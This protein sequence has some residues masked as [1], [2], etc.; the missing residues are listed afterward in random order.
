MPGASAADQRDLQIVTNS[1]T[2]SGALRFDWPAVHVG[3]AEYP[4]GPTGVTVFH[5][6]DRAQVAIDYRGGGPG[7]VNAPYV[8]LGY[9]L[10]ELDSLVFAGGSWYG[11]EATTAVASA[12]KDDG[13]RDGD[14]FSA[15]ANIA[16]SIGSIIFDFGP[17]RLNEIYPDKRLAQAAYRASEPGVF[18]LGATGAGRLAKSGGFFGCDAHSGQGGAFRQIGDLKVAAFTVVNSVG[19]ITDRSGNVQACYSD[20]S[21]TFDAPLRATDLM[22]KK[23]AATGASS[24][25]T[26]SVVIINQAMSHAELDRL[27]VQVHMSM[28]RAIQP[29]ATIYD[30][31]VLYAVTTNELKK[32]IMAPPQL[33][34]VASELM[35]DAVLSS[36][37]DQPRLDSLPSRALPQ[38]DI[39]H[40]DGRY[41]FSDDAEL[42]ISTNGTRVFAQSTDIRRVYQFPEQEPV[43][44]EALSDGDYHLPGR[45]PLVLRFIDERTIALNPG[46]WEQIGHRN[47]G[48]NPQ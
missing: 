11:L 27:A 15:E 21:W 16:M 34:V 37:P 5:F 26:I 48:A 20:P 18:P 45:Y 39:A 38:P 31:D 36:V 41:R 13:L 29:F 2:V 10:Q 23:P 17:R 47:K 4:S 42:E 35:W 30:G 32:P 40:M 19:V 6:P 14:A 22:N 28:A 1:K 7:T 8:D 33:G 44:L 12:M 25:T 9:G 24:N 43:E 3:T 46:R